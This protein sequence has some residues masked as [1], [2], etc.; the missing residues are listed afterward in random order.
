MEK[1]LEGKPVA[2]AIGQKTMQAVQI[3]REKGICPGLAIVRVGENDGDI[4]YERSATKRCES[5][6]IYV[7]KATFP[8]EVTQ[9]DLI[10]GI[11]EINVDDQI[12]GCLILRPLPDH[13]DDALI[14]RT[15]LP[16][17]DVDGITD[18][19]LASVFSGSDAG[20]A[21]CTAEACIEVLEHYD[22]EMQGKNALVLGR[23]LVIGKPVAMLLLRK[24]ATVTICHTKTDNL[25]AICQKADILIAAAGKQGLVTQ[26]FFNEKQVVLDVG[27]H[28]SSEGKI[29]GDVDFSAA[30][31]TVF[32]ASPVPGGIGAVTTAVLAAN[33]VK[34][35]T[36]IDSPLGR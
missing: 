14:R 36:R 11:K 4:A 32:A 12:H 24:N 7:R 33:V 1:K 28:V 3:L 10:E 30:E 29:A 8:K 21:P 19:S 25:A 17:K 9:A 34:A 23:S 26:D 6:G 15:L 16:E 5:L 22:I 20:F 18:G 13:I 35:A 2:A 31:A 27:I